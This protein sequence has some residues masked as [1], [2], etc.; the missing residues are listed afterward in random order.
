MVADVYTRIVKQA[1]FHDA[2]HGFDEFGL[3][4]PSLAGAISAAAPIY[5]TYFRVESIGAE[6]IPAVGPAILVAN[7]AGVLPVDAAMLC[8]DVLR[9]TDPPRIPRAVADHFVP[10]LPLV[11][12]VFA[13]F[14]VVSGTRANVHHLLQRGEL[15]A[16]W[17]EGVSGPAK[18]YRDRYRIQKWSVGFAEL[19][20][21]YRAPIIPIAIIGA[22]ESWPL[23]AK[24]RALRLFGAPYLPIPA[25]PIPLPARYHI[26]YG[27]PLGGDRDPS[28]A[29]DPQ[30]VQAVADAARTEV[31]RLIERGLA[32]RH[33]VF[34]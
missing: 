13:R 29:A 18:L 10:G 30:V 32:E 6:H 23:V 17:P 28:E 15:V 5:D 7:H 34:R 14:G 1:P 20:I 25:S 21:R 24:I 31:E 22:E 12:T 2:G 16:I 8:M 33:G 9:R 27:P 26:R 19:A 4:P 3:H 11:S